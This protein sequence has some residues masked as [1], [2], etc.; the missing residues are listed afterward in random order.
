MLMNKN[1][2]KRLSYVMLPVMILYTALPATAYGAEEYTRVA[3]SVSSSQAGNG[4]SYDIEG[5]IRGAVAEANA[6]NK[7]A[8]KI[9]ARQVNPDIEILTSGNSTTSVS[10]GSLLGDATPSYSPSSSFAANAVNGV[11]AEV[12]PQTGQV[13]VTLNNIQLAGISP[14]VGIN[15]GISNSN[16]A[17]NKI[18][19]FQQGWQYSA[20]YI[21]KDPATQALTLNMNGGTCYVIDP[22]FSSINADGTLYKSGLRY[23]TTNAINFRQVT[24]PLPTGWPEP[25]VPEHCKEYQYILSQ[26]NGTNEFFDAWGK[27]IGQSDK[28]GNFI[29]YY[30]KEPNGTD[31]TQTRLVKITDSFDND[32][33]FGYNSDIY[34]VTMPDSQTVEY[35]FSTPYQITITG[36]NGRKTILNYDSNNRLIQITYPTGGC[37]VYT[38]TENVIAY[39]A[40]GSFAAV[41]QVDQHPGGVNDTSNV[42]T[43]LYNYN[44][45]QGTNFTG[46]GSGGAYSASCDALMEG[47]YGQYQYATIVT[48]K[49]TQDCGGDITSTQTFNFLHLPTTTAIADSNK[50]QLATTSTAYQ[51]QGGITTGNFSQY[52]ALGSSYNLPAVTTSTV[53]GTGTSAGRETKVE[54]AYDDYCRPLKVTNY[55]NGS[56]MS[57]TSTSYG[58][59]DLVTSQS[60]YDNIDGA[61]TAAANTLSSDGKFIATSIA[62]VDSPVA[63]DKTTNLTADNYGRMTSSKLSNTSESSASTTSYTRSGSLLTI[64]T[65]DALGNST[66]QTIDISNGRIQTQTDAN[67]NSVTYTY[68][69]TGL[70][71]TKTYPDGSWE[72]TNSSKTNTTVASSS[73]GKTLT[74]T[75]DGFGR[76]IKLEDNFGRV[77][78]VQYNVLGKPSIKTDPFG[79]STTYTYDYQ[80]R[81]LSQVDYLNNVKST[82]YDDVAQTVTESI[83]AI[84]A[85]VSYLDDNGNVQKQTNLLSSSVSNANSKYNGKN[86]EMGSWLTIGDNSSAPIMSST[87]SYDVDNKVISAGITTADGTNGTSTFVLN[88]FG[89]V[90]SRNTTYSAV[91]PGVEGPGSVSSETKTYN[92]IG[93]LTSL[94]NQKGQVITYTYD[95]NG[96]LLT[97][98]DFAGNTFT[99]SYDNM[100]RLTK[101]SGPVYTLDYTYY[102]YDPLS[103]QPGSEG[104]LYTITLSQNGTGI[105]TMTYTYDTHTNLTSVSHGS[106]KTMSMTYDFYDR[107]LTMIDFSGVTNYY[108]YDTTVPNNII[109]VSNNNGTAT[110][111]YYTSDDNPLFGDRK[112]IKSVTYSNGVTVSYKYTTPANKA[113]MLSSRETNDS[114]NN[115]ISGTYYTYDARDRVISLKQ[116]SSTSSDSNSNNTRNFIY[117]D[118]NQVIQETVIDNQN[119]CNVIT[120]T[121]YTFDIKG[122][123]TKRVITNSSGI[124]QA[125]N[126]Y[127]YNSI[128]H[129]TS[130]TDNT[131][132]VRK[133]TYDRNGNMTQI[134]SG[135]VTLKHFTYNTLNQLIEYTD[136]QG[137]DVCYDYNA[138]GLRKDKYVKANQAGTQINYYYSQG[139]EILNEEDNT[140]LMSSYLMAGGRAL[141]AVNGQVQWYITNGKDVVATLDDDTQKATNTYNYNA[142][143]EDTNLNNGG[144]VVPKTNTFNI[145]DNPYKYSGYYLDEESGMYYLQARYYSPEL[146]RF[147]SRDTYDLS[148]RYAYGDGDPISNV[149]PS[150]HMIGKIGRK[151]MRDLAVGAVALETGGVGDAAL[152]A[153]TVEKIEVEKIE[154]DAVQQAVQR[155]DKV[156]ILKEMGATRV[157]TGEPI[158]EEHVEEEEMFDKP[159]SD[160]DMYQKISNN[161]SELHWIDTGSEGMVFGYTNTKG[162]KMAMKFYHKGNQADKEV[163]LWNSYYEDTLK[164]D[165]I[166]G[167]RAYEFNKTRV[168]PFIPEP[169]YHEFTED[170]I[171]QAQKKCISQGYCIKD[172][173]INLRY[174]NKKAYPIDFGYTGSVQEWRMLREQEDEQVINTTLFI[175]SVK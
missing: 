17:T 9:A 154:K 151:I 57:T 165:G 157:V 86:I 30:Y 143:G 124:V 127:T 19:G 137:V 159:L 142:Y 93:Q 96:N 67:G 135:K 117:N 100:N 85:A 82:V 59:Y 4:S 122:N 120:S 6:L 77:Y 1:T 88:L 65:T 83:N 114:S 134:V 174:Y 94:K 112:T 58:S 92:K 106:G 50:A 171:S 123:I 69:S 49:R 130:I 43:T 35:D 131:G 140:G 46:L 144:T 170:E 150:G 10:N 70:I 136:N 110:Y 95:A 161:N 80:G 22:S 89:D 29:R 152:L 26:S 148:N 98:V 66:S 108:T 105:D 166:E 138:E 38:Y 97:M 128:N 76:V 118:L 64:T 145:N 139:G 48:S 63:S 27:I 101:K 81:E 55:N 62:S 116:Q 52:D 79:H 99:Y 175:K 33:N 54:T 75:L 23:V 8:L 160:E 3:N 11:G 39:S 24:D 71:V 125:S 44:G 36:T 7:N 68:D 18:Y 146:M 40:T 31:P 21:Y 158:I 162:H 173:G 25:Q 16:D 121:A 149:D 129:L 73:N 15:L 61:T 147:I 37:V 5:A 102:P 169:V 103:K 172:M 60:I 167:G 41:T 72:T 45:I 2:R 155:A 132:V 91:S 163:A 153:E 104:Q 78:T 84:Q 115:L 42:V 107:I 34:T 111:S 20:D 156:K 74:T 28:F 109:S 14:E 47:N 56:V 53:Y 113:P 126:T 164:N 141:R 51:G 119:P 90:V 12:N 87:S 13:S 32:I 133:F 168:T